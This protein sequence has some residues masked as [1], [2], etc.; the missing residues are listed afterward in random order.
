MVLKA[1]SLGE[2]VTTQF[3]AESK[4]AVIEVRLG[5]RIVD[6]G[7]LAVHASLRG[8]YASDQNSEYTESRPI[9]KTHSCSLKTPKS[10]SDANGPLQSAYR[11]RHFD[12]NG[13]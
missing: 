6:N 8:S 3:K 13:S 4:S 2:P 12:V 10:R 11:H 1:F 5:P 9:S 7:I